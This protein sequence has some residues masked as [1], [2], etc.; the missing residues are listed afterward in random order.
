EPRKTGPESVVLP[1]HHSPKSKERLSSFLFDGAKVQHF[2]NI[3]SIRAFFSSQ[4]HIF[5][6]FSA[7]FR[8]KFSD[9]RKSKY[10][11]PTYYI[12]NF[13]CKYRKIQKNERNNKFNR[14]NH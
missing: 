5:L 1:L 10:I 14:K 2:W 8:Q 4:K 9:I 6:L 7:S 11:C 3:Q 13:I 12:K